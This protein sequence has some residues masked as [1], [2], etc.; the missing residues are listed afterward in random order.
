M[1]V[2]CREAARALGTSEATLTSRRVRARL[3]VPR[4][5]AC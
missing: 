3:C 5:L 4:A 1:G 2:S